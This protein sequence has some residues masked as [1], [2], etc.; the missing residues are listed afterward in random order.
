MKLERAGLYAD[1]AEAGVFLWLGILL[2]GIVSQ[3]ITRFFVVHRLKPLIAGTGCVF[4]LWGIQQVRILTSANRRRYD[5][6]EP[7]HDG[8]RYVRLS[9]FLILAVCVSAAVFQY[10]HM[11]PLHRSSD[12]SAAEESI[13]QTELESQV[14][15]YSDAKVQVMEDAAGGVSG[16]AGAGTDTA[17]TH[18]VNQSFSTAAPR[19]LTGYYPEK[20]LIVISDTESAGWIKEIEDHTQQYTGWTVTMKGCV[21]T[22]PSVFGPGMF[23]PSRQL[24]TCCIA[25]L[26][27]IGFTCLYDVN[28][29]FAPL[30]R[31][32]R[33]VLV[34]GIIQ[35]GSYQGQPEPQVVC[36]S[37]E[38]G[39]PPADP[40]VYP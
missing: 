19:S 27:L 36:T 32:G 37:V 16:T 1:C 7:E 34:S 18:A 25:D 39:T 38:P 30:I 35:Q 15:R 22:D 26:S 8:I 4:L 31:D 13:S 40:Y 10:V 3:N 14:H 6:D 17:Y 2:V 21:V 20:K 12:S 11:R 29:P 28:G 24:M 33:W 23:C 9:V 5:H